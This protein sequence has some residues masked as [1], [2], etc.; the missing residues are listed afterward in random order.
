MPIIN[1][2]VT[3]ANTNLDGFDNGYIKNTKL[4]RRWITAQILRVMKRSGGYKSW[5]KELDDRYKFKVLADEANVI[6]HLDDATKNER[7]KFF[8]KEVITN[9]INDYVAY[10]VV[11]CCS[12]YHTFKTTKG[13][14]SR[15]TFIAEI[16]T[17][18]T[19]IRNSDDYAEIYKLIKKLPIKQRHNKFN[20]P[21]WDR[22][23]MGA[24]AYYA[25][26][27]LVAYDGCLINGWGRD[28]SLE[29]IEKKVND[30]RYDILLT[31]LKQTI[32]QNQFDLR[33][34]LNRR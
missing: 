20:S 28:R 30:G 34:Y 29:F 4:H 2:N 17:I 14:K 27:N 5:L 8:N 12:P 31:L 21:S 32:N 25:L 9:T 11:H 15:D 1:S 18:T 16:S 6:A 22:A 3:I 23:F 13:L 7:T 33:T 26:K 19:Q 10:I 24:G